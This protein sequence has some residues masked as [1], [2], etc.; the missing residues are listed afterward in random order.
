MTGDATA[1]VKNTTGAILIADEE[2]VTEK[3][4]KVNRRFIL[5]H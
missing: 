3:N 5:I 2:C 4:N 1:I